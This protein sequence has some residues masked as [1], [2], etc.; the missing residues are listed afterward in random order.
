MVNK[1][2]DEKTGMREGDGG[3]ESRARPE[4]QDTMCAQKKGECARGSN[5]TKI[6]KSDLSSSKSRVTGMSSV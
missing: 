5:V 2:K 6:P 1:G 3:G 4:E